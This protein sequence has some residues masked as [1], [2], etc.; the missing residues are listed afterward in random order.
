MRYP[1][2]SSASSSSSLSGRLRHIISCCTSDTPPASGVCPP[3]SSGVAVPLPNA[4]DAGVSSQRERLP[5]GVP[6]TVRAPTSQSPRAGVSA[7]LRCVGVS[8]TVL[9]VLAVPVLLRVGVGA[10]HLETGF[11]SGSSRFWLYA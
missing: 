7:Q 4:R 5:P 2:G 8:L 1:P 6:S 3:L 10:S 11:A 9:A